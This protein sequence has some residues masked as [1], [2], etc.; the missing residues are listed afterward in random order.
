MLRAFSEQTDD[1]FEILVAEDGSDARTAE[2]VA[3]WAPMFRVPLK[4]VSHADDGRR[5]ARI[6]D[7]AALEAQG[8]FLVFVDGDCIPRTSFVAG[9]R[10]AALPGWYLASKRIKL[11]PSFSARVLSGELAI[12]A[13]V[14]RDLD[15][16]RPLANVSA[17]HFVPLRDR[18]R[19]WRPDQPDFLPP[20]NAYGFC[21]GMHRADLERV[22]GWDARF[23]GWGNEDVDLAVR[24]GRIGLRCGWPGPSATVLHLWHPDGRD[25]GRSGLPGERAASAG[26]E[27]ER[28]DGGAGRTTR[29]RGSGQREAG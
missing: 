2:V 12:W 5:L 20:F 14:R 3:R 23:I 4:H 26:D 28:A 16:A 8:D 11:S 19:P 10:R 1:D 7:L 29:A 24:L 27:S 13:L 9:I 15:A 21:I 6:V 17:G 22:N 18:R 25:P